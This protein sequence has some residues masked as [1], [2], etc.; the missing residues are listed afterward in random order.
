MAYGRMAYALCMPV[1]TG[2]TKNWRCLS[3]DLAQKTSKPLLLTV[4]E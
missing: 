4:R 2:M 3:N 1:F